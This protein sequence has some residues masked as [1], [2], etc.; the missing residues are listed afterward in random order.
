VKDKE[1]EDLPAVDVEEDVKVTRMSIDISELSS[2]GESNY[3]Y[4]KRAS[5]DIE[6]EKVEFHAC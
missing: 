6:D 5:T 1:E 2:E 3:L 4:E